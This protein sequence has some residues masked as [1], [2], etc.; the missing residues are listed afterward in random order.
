ML[1][2]IALFELRYQLRRPI[3]LISFLIFGLITFS[4]TASGGNI[5]VN[6]PWRIVV[7]FSFFSIFAMFMSL[8]TLSDVALRDRNS[9]MDEIIRAQPVRIA[10]YLGAKFAGAYAVAFMMFLGIALGYAIGGLMPWLSPGSVGPFRF[11]AYAIGVLLVLAPNLYATGALFFTVAKLTRSLMAA[12]LSAL[13]L[14]ILFVVMAL[15]LRDPAQRTMAA[16][17][18]PFGIFAFILDTMRWTFDQRNGELIP[19]NGLFVWN[20]LLWIGIGTGLLA[21]SFTVFDARERKPRVRGVDAPGTAQPSAML[22]RPVVA[23][24]GVGTWEQLVVRTRHETRAILRSWSF[25]ILMGLGVILS[26]IVLAAFG[27]TGRL[28]NPPPSDVV[29]YAVTSAMW[30][31]LVLLPIAYGGELIWR[32]RRAKIAEIIDAT[33]APTAVFIASKI[34]GLGLVIVGFLVAALVTGVGYQLAKGATGIEMRFYFVKLVVEAGLPALMYGILAIFIQTLVNRK[35]VGLLFMLTVLLMIAILPELGY[36]NK[37]FLPFYIPAAPVTGS[38]VLGTYLVW[39]YLSHALWF[40][41]YWICVSVLIALVSY[42]I[43][44]RGSNS[45]GSRVGRSYLAVNR[46]FLITAAIAL[47]GAIGT[48]LYIH[49]NELI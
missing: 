19:L 3:A 35:F 22:T 18:D 39:D 34:A 14:L 15:L 2:N 9:R 29:A 48:G 40:V 33:P 1:G 43:W 20:R 30:L 24:G 45:F 38:N 16:L 26:M 11:G 8:A 36:D 49:L 47:A 21:L 5:P 27:A 12:Y 25:I 32:D 10:P 44:V 7:T 42:M 31:V 41:G 4:I 17:L 28:P 23:A 13:L 37:L 46:V 6:S